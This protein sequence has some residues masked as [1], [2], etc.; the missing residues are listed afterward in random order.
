MAQA[1]DQG[2]HLKSDRRGLVAHQVFG[3]RGHSPDTWK[4]Q[5]R[6][7]AQ[8]PAADPCQQKKFGFIHLALG[9]VS[10]KKLFRINNPAL[11]IFGKPLAFIFHTPFKTVS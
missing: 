4:G 5:G 8:Q 11:K 7:C 2:L 3:L 6:G 1:L 10:K 9:Q